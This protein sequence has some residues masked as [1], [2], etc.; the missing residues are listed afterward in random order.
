MGDFVVLAA[1]GNDD[2]EFN[3]PFRK[4]TLEWNM[5]D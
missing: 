2:G 4:N 3:C 5:D 1:T